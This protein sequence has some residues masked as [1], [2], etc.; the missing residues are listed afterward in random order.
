MFVVAKAVVVV[1]VVELVVVVVELVVVGVVVVVFVEV[2]VVVVVVVTCCLLGISVNHKLS[3]V[4]NEEYLDYR[5]LFDASFVF[6]ES[7]IRYIL[8]Q[9]WCELHIMPCQHV[10]TQ[11]RCKDLSRLP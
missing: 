10:Y 8:N 11:P 4:Y 6:P 2:V 3:C 7:K 9:Q 5:I 1:V